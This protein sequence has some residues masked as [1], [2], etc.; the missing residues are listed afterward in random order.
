M[1]TGKVLVLANVEMKQLGGLITHGMIYCATK[2]EGES[3]KVELIRP[4]EEAPV[5]SKVIIKECNHA[6]IDVNKW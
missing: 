2:Q 1:T 5:G 6:T 4:T 3:M